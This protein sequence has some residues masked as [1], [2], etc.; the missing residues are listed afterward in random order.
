LVSA[1]GKAK[2]KEEKNR[3]PTTT[4]EDIRGKK[5]GASRGRERATFR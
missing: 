4:K 1:G 2:T 3:T 5:E